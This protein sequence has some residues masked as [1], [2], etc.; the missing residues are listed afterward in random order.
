MLKGHLDAVVLSA[1]ATG[2]SYGYAMIRQINEKTNGA[3][4]LPEGTIYPTL[5]RLENNGLVASHWETAPS[6][7]KRRTYS[8]TDSGR[9]SLRER[10]DQWKNFAQAIDLML[11]TKKALI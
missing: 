6:G 1:I 5:H 9:E 7:R 11:D 3:I 2:A 8:L 10:C 4:D